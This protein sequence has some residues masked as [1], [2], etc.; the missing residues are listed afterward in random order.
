MNPDAL[1]FQQHGHRQLH[2]ENPFKLALKGSLQHVTASW[3]DD[4]MLNVVGNRTSTQEAKSATVHQPRDGKIALVSVPDRTK[5]EKQ[6]IPQTPSGKI[7]RRIMRSLLQGDDDLGDL[8]IL[9][10]TTHLK[11]L[12]LHIKEQALCNGG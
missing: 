11:N 6:G 12:I 1:Y 5:V 4:G 10:N 2:W 7:I 3:F 8:S 9:A